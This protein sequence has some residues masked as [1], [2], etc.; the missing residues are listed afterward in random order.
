MKFLG[1]AADAQSGVDSGSKEA[2][3]IC[4]GMQA[5]TLPLRRPGAV[6]FQE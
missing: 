6:K 4:N 3:A 1:L 2:G 5:L